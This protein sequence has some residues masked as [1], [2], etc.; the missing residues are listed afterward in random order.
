MCS[1]KMEA[2]KLHTY[3]VL[4]RG[5]N[6]GGKNKIPMADLRTALAKAGF[7]GVQTYIQSG[8]VILQTNLNSAEVASKVEK[9]LTASFKL[10]SQLIKTVAINLADYKRVVTDAP[11]E[12]GADNANYRYYVLF[13]IDYNVETA[14]Q[15][16]EVR[17]G[18]DKAWVGKNVIYFRLP[19]ITNPNVHKSRL[20]KIT[21]K[22]IYKFITMRNWR[23]TQKLLE[24]VNKS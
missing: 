23:T 22:P 11:A 17:E 9:I 3:I 5:I 21:E 6:V 20:N 4:L 14:M 19:A 18:V 7:S 16:I 24:M 13:L 15:Q 8:N 10:D 1:L 12:F 2:N